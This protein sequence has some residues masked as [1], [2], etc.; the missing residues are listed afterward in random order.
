MATAHADSYTAIAAVITEYF[1]GLHYSDSTRLARVFHPRAHYVSPTVHPLV[2][3]SMAEYFPIVDARP[4]PA[5]RG[6]ARQDRIISIELGGQVLAFVRAECAIGPKR[7]TD[8]LTLVHTD[9][10]W[11]IMSKVFHFDLQD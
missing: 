8:F 10:R 2:Y 7:F 5:S 6:E 11:Q 4:S 3:R 9:G 1:D